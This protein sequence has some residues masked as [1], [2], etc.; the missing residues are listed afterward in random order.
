MQSGDKNKYLHFFVSI[1]LL[2]P[3]KCREPSFL[4]VFSTLTG[5]ENAVVLL[6]RTYTTLGS[7][8][9]TKSPAPPAPE[10]AWAISNLSSGTEN[11]CHVYRL[12]FYSSSLSISSIPI[13]AASSNVTATRWRF[14]GISERHKEHELSKPGTRSN[15]RSYVL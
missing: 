5:L 2:S 4:C 3:P 1:A 6:L 15:S 10:T 12:G 11:I 8:S 14:Q 9:S 7:T 13:P